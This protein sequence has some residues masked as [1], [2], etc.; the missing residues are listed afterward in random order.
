MAFD[1]TSKAVIVTGACGG[2]GAA[3]ARLAAE[4]G[5]DLVLVDR[6]SDRLEAL[7]G[8]VAAS[9]QQRRTPLTLCCDVASEADMAAMAEKALSR[10]G[11][12]DVLVSCAGILRTSG[13]PRLISDTSIEEWRSVIEINLTGT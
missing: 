6:D 12:I 11:R 13:Q 9:G 3:T 2:I 7:A 8:E 10:Y 1:L 5:A 4:A